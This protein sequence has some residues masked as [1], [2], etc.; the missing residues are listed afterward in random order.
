[1]SVHFHL[2][3]GAWQDESRAWR[4]G[5]AAIEAGLAKEVFY[6]G[7]KVAGL[8][9]H[10]EMGLGQAIL[11]LGA[12]PAR[13][14][15][16]RWVRAAGLPRWWL[17]CRRQLKPDRVSLIVAHSLASLPI[18]V[19]LS[20]RWGTPLLYDAHELETERHGWSWP[21]RRFAKLIEARL[22]SAC[23]HTIVV[24]DSIQGWYES[25]YPG[26]SVSTVRNVPSQS[27]VLGA[28]N[29][30]E[31]LGLP[32]HVILFVY[33]GVLGGGRGLPELIDAFDNLG[34]DRHLVLIGSG[35]LEEALRAK[36]GG[37][38]NVHLHDRVPQSELISLISG[39]D[40]GVMVPSTT[41]LSYRFAMPNK[42]FEYAAAR[43]AICVGTGPDLQRF[44]ASYPA[45][46]TADLSVASLRQMALSWSRE[47]LDRL[48]P[49][50]ANFRPP[51]WEEER[52]RLLA[53]YGSALSR[54]NRR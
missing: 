10:E 31:T 17:A 54:T 41:A 51:S 30:R 32:S 28:S 43:L 18:G 3:F 33:C 46:R 53:A 34:P 45:A 22:I 40:V 29:L 52:L 19:W 7:H 14:G 15:S 25:T 21:I 11:R 6:V 24:S 1:M 27:G 23:N 4:A 39:A 38:P 35:P 50:I 16:S 44:A 36:I 26:L 48:R 2:Y 37:I 47:E 20:K 12:E 8:S 49:L 5:A 13:P 9:E 42:V